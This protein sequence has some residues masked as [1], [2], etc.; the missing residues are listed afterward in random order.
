MDFK[1]HKTIEEYFISLN[2]TDSSIFP[3]GLNYIHRYNY[4]TQEINKWINEYV[5]KG[6]ITVDGGYLNDHGPDHIKKVILRISQLLSSPDLTL[7]EYE[8]YIL[9]VAVHIHDCGNILGRKGH[10][11]NS[12]EVISRLGVNAG[13]DRI[14]WD[15]IF[16]IAEAHGGEP[17]DKIRELVDEKILDFTVR[18]RILAALLKFGDELADDRTRASKFQLGQGLLPKE[19]EVYHKYSY[20]L[21]SVDINIKARQINLSFD[22]EESDLIR[23]YHKKGE[24]AGDQIHLVN[25]IYS[26]TFKTHLERIYCMRFLRGMVNIEKIRVHIQIILD[27]KDSRNRPLKKSIT[28]DLGEVGYPSAN[29]KDIFDICPDLKEFTGEYIESKLKNKTMTDVAATYK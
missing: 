3:H 14:E 28:Y 12:I 15:T 29:W 27:E 5:V 19:A 9:L 20:C 22:V 10:E 18:K 25:E 16:E 13:Q 7:S 6:A 23:T 8:T 26:R 4:A 11:F 1:G 21:H 24:G 2:G 17:K